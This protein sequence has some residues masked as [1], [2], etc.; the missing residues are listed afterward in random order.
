[1]RR[2]AALLLVGAILLSPFAGVAAEQKSSQ[3]TAKKSEEAP[4]VTL[5]GT[6]MA[7]GK[8]AKGNVN[9]VA[10]RTEKGDYKVVLK[11]KGKELLKMVGKKV[12]V[13]GK[14]REAKG[15]KSINISEFKEAGA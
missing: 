4:Q 12:E 15:K 6:V 5:K 14:I 13:T 1:M 8:D 3:S 2:L 10:I 7:V 9:A 11:G